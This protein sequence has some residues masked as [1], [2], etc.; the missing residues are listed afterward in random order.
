[1][2]L[3]PAVHERTC[4]LVFFRQEKKVRKKLENRLGN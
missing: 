3:R 1:M 2:T 4:F